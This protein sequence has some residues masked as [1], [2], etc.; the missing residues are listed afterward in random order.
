MEDAAADK[1]EYEPP[2]L[3][4][5]GTAGGLTEAGTFGTGDGVVEQQ[6]VF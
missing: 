4:D 5:L 2:A 6:S 3:V 1:S